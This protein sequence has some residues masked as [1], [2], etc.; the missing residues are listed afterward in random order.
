MGSFITQRFIQ[1]H[2]YKLAGVILSGTGRNPSLILNLG[3]F[4]TKLIILFKGPDINLNLWLNLPLA[5]IIK[6]TKTEELQLTGLV[7][8]KGSR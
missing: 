8:I 1:I 4:L 7:V 5:L 3:A 6:N 2:N